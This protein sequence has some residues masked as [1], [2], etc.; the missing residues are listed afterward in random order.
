M[1]ENKTSSRQNL[2]TLR[3][4]I[5]ALKSKLLVENVQIELDRALRLLDTTVEDL[6]DNEEQARPSHQ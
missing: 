4:L 1:T 2:E 3:T 5:T 6:S